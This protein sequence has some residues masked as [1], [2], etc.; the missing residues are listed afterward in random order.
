VRLVLQCSVCGTVNPVGLAECGTC[1][2]TGL[3]NLRLLFECPRC[4][5]LD[6]RPSCE[7]CSKLLSL[8]EPYEVAPDPVDPA[9]LA[10]RWGV[11]ATEPVTDKPASAEP[12]T[13]AWEE[14]LPEAEMLP[15][16][17]TTKAGEPAVKGEVAS[18]EEHGEAR[19][20]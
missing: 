12:L 18:K 5:R 6:L 19:P 9:E 2:A 16:D 14:V 17:E 10:R 8:D 20:G 7:A 13:P 4:F 11:D 1:L 15:L 3:E